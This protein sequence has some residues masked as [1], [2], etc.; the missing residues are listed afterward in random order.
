VTDLLVVF[1]DV[2]DVIT[3]RIVSF[4]HAHRVVCEVDIAVVAEE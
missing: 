1:D 3:A 4:P 2:P